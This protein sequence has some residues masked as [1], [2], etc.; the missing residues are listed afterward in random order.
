[1]TCTGAGLAFSQYSRFDK[2]LRNFNKKTK[3]IGKANFFI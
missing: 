3:R 1:M 2:R